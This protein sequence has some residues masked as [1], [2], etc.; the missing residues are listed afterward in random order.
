MSF[1]NT[2]TFKTVV[3]HAPLVSIDLIV[4]NQK[5]DKFLFGRRRNKPAQDFWFVP[6][7]RI[8]K[9]ENLDDAFVRLVEDELGFFS[10]R[11]DAKLLGVFEHFYLDSIFDYADCP[12]GTHYI[13][14]AYEI[15]Y[16]VTKDIKLEQHIE[17]QWLSRSQILSSD[18]VHTYSKNYFY[19]S[20]MAV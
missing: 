5:G 7:G 11:K 20:S 2:E 9:N 14:I 17:W 18:C 15:E 4:R 6:G 19:S 13:V 12:S 16:K 1:L 10:A 3:Q 8:R